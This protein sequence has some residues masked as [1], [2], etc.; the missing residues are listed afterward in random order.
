MTF[1]A[2]SEEA[3]SVANFYAKAFEEGRQ[4]GQSEGWQEAFE[5]FQAVVPSD[6][7][8]V[9]TSTNRELPAM[10][11]QSHI[12]DLGFG[13]RT[14]N[15][16]LRAEIKTVGDLIAKSEEQLNRIPNFGMHSVNEVIEVL[17]RYGYKLAPR[18]A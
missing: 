5:A 1:D 15:C 16:L 18:Q 2:D 3:R 13:V 9:S 12:A 8:T 17:G 10:P 14:Y 11:F 6:F 7:M 4:K